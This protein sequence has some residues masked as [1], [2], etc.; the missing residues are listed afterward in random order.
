MATHDHQIPISLANRIVLQ[1]GRRYEAPI[2][3]YEL[4]LEISGLE[5]DFD[6]K[7]ELIYNTILPLVNHGM[8]R[9][10]HQDGDKYNSAFVLC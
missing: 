1:C 7:A 5:G 2:T 4:V 8:M 6:Q 10:V 9:C 3:T